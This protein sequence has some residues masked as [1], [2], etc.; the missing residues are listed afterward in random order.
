MNTY[1]AVGV[2][3][4]HRADFQQVLA[5]HAI[6]P[7]KP[8]FGKRLVNYNY[9]DEDKYASPFLPSAR[10]LTIPPKPFF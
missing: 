5:K 4:L 2:L 9:V 8:H 3:T 1:L 7:A 10:E 6:P